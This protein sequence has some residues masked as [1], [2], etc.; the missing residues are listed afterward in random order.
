MTHSDKVGEVICQEEAKF[1]LC[2]V[3][4]IIQGQV[5]QLYRRPKTLVKASTCR[6]ILHTLVQAGRKQHILTADCTLSQVVVL[7][8]HGFSWQPPFT[9][10]FVILWSDFISAGLD[11]ERAAIW[12]PPSAAADAEQQPRRLF[13]WQSTCELG[14]RKPDPGPAEAVGEG[15]VWVG[16]V[17]PHFVQV[18]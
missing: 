2:M 8:T 1:V 15:G 11:A 7:S 9:L 17:G 5:S 3:Y 12:V 4:D 10:V 14:C 18:S 16:W 6:Q 13:C